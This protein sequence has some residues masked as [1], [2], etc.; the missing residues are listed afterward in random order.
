MHVFFT[1]SEWN[2]HHCGLHETQD[3]IISYYTYHK[4]TMHINCVATDLHAQAENLTVGHQITS[5]LLQVLFIVAFIHL[6]QNRS[7][8][9]TIK[10]SFT[11]G[12]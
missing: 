12:P 10:S 1:F 7:Q 8:L 11:T 5:M 4:I 2:A 3:L 9:K 6:F